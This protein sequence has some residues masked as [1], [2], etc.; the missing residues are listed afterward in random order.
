M[1]KRAGVVWA[2]NACYRTV[3]KGRAD[4]RKEYTTF[5]AP[6]CPKDVP[7][8]VFFATLEHT[9]PGRMEK[10]R[11]AVKDGLSRGMQPK[12][13]AS[14]N[15]KLGVAASL[16]LLATRIDDPEAKAILLSGDVDRIKA[17]ANVL[18]E[19]KP[20]KGNATEEDYILGKKSYSDAWD[21]DAPFVDDH[22]D[23][24]ETVED[25]QDD[26]DDDAQTDEQA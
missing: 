6:A 8:S 24:G 7:L 19:A 12:E 2:R 11:A 21:K 26:E 5:T 16:S 17:H 15:G 3:N 23:D 20:H 13:V 1:N 14:A 18:H 9:A 22:K 10:I 4:E 25:D